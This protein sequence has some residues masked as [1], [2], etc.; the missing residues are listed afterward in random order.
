M[1]KKS[2]ALASVLVLTL[3][4]GA[5]A[6]AEDLRRVDP[7]SIWA[8]PDPRP[9]QT[10]N[11]YWAEK[12]FTVHYREAVIHEST[13]HTYFMITG[14]NVTSVE[15]YGGVQQIYDGRRVAIFSVWDVK[16][17]C[18]GA[19]CKPEDADPQYRV[20]LHQKGEYTVTE[21]F[22]YELTGL[23]SMIYDANW[24]I[25]ERIQWLVVQE[26]AGKSTVIAAAYR[27][28]EGP[29]RFIASYLVPKRY[30]I[31]LTGGYSF[32]E[33]YG[34]PQPMVTRSMTVGPTIL[35]D[36]KGTQVIVNNMI[37]F[38]SQA[39][40]NHRTEVSG[41][42]TYI[43]IGASDDVNAMPT[44]SVRP[45]KPT[46]IPD[47]SEGKKLLKEI[48]KD[49]STLEAETPVQPVT[50]SPAVTTSPKATPKKK[51]ITCQKGKT[52][53]KITAVAPR[54]PSGFKLKK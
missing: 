10:F 35:E 14:G 40:K 43:A 39:T 9:G 15:Y 19:D 47:Y 23:K 45:L 50:K 33:D 28:S 12:Q 27:L 18:T 11:E 30:P 37:A 32:V 48:I 24:K 6:Q 8:D 13:N 54:C 7:I 2:L 20:Q 21:R 31:A 38:A 1:F 42:G 29:W 26:P 16:S 34:P 53:K 22:G 49:V 41:T 17:N 36:A 52:I 46:S 44:K 4:I 3:V 5:S 51:T 25:G